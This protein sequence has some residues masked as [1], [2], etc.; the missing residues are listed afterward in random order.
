M[1]SIYKKSQPLHS[2][3]VPGDDNGD[4]N[5]QQV[6]EDMTSKFR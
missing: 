1:M 3:L 6:K 4:Y 5:T 2:K